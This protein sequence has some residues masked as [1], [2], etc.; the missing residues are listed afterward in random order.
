VI[1][2]LRASDSHLGRTDIR[3]VHSRKHPP[4]DER[5]R[6]LFC[7]AAEPVLE[8]LRDAG[9]AIVLLHDG[10]YPDEQ[11]GGVAVWGH[12]RYWEVRSSPFDIVDRD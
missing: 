1:F 2:L 8:S 12:G 9:S 6:D 5:E 11:G 7:V 4:L 10:W 3:V